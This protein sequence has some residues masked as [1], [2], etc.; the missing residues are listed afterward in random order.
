MV[1]SDTLRIPL[2]PGRSRRPSC[3]VHSTVVVETRSRTNGTSVRLTSTALNCV[4]GWTAVPSTP[5]SA[6][7][8]SV[9]CTVSALHRP[10]GRAVIPSPSVTVAVVRW[11]VIIAVIR[12]P[13]II[14][15]R[16]RRHERAKRD[17]A[18]AA[19]DQEYSRCT[20]C[21]ALIFLFRATLSLALM[22]SAIRRYFAP[23]RYANPP[24][25]AALVSH[26]E[27]RDTSV[28]ITAPPA[29][30]P[31]PQRTSAHL[32]VRLSQDEA[33]RIAV[34]AERSGRRA[35]ETICLQLNG[36]RGFCPFTSQWR[37][38]D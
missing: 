25:P 20:H 37:T 32:E 13:R 35:F 16:L 26:V 30:F 15:L 31:R 22:A 28:R 21:V 9:G 38:A 4:T 24:L 8:T 36:S 12:R 17:R 10:T 5:S 19:S 23:T 3:S 18:H 2:Q 29:R 11:R 33:R 7:R 34:N 1:Y 6:N 14:I 27:R